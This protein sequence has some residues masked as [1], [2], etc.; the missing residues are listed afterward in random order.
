MFVRTFGTFEASNVSNRKL[1][2]NKYSQK[3]QLSSSHPVVWL[4]RLPSYGVCFTHGITFVGYSPSLFDVTEIFPG[5]I[6][7]II[8]MSVRTTSCDLFHNAS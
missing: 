5:T 3:S 8:T 1:L 4:P 6:I 2:R 7:P